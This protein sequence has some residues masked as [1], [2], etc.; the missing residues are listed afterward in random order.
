MCSICPASHGYLFSL[1]SQAARHECLSQM[2]GIC[3]VQYRITQ[4]DRG[5]FVI[6]HK[7]SREWI[8]VRLHHDAFADPLP[9]LR[10]SGPELFSIHA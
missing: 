8:V 7:L 3:Q 6:P 9:E 1:Q 2:V 10:L 4:Y 5:F